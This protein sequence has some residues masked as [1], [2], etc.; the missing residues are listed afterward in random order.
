[1]QRD[2]AVTAASSAVAIAQGGTLS[3]SP[4]SYIQRHIT[5]CEGVSG[6][7]GRMA[8]L[9]QQCMVLFSIFVRLRRTLTG[10]SEI[11]SSWWCCPRLY[12]AL[13]AKQPSHST[14]IL[15]RRS[16][17]LQGFNNITMVFSTQDCQRHFIVSAANQTSF[18]YPT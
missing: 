14:E 3:T 2:I 15:R 8:S 7:L 9:L 11:K 10:A 5:E 17:Q 1:M 6:E 12:R 16:L 4:D 18:Y 13:R